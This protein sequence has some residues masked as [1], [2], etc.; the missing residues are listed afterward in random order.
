MYECGTYPARN[1]EIVLNSFYTPDDIK[2]REIADDIIKTLIVDSIED[3]VVAAYNFVI[4][5]DIYTPD[6][7]QF[8][9]D[10]WW[11]YPYETLGHVLVGGSARKMYGDC[12]DTSFL[13][14]SLLIALGIPSTNIRVGVSD[15][16]AWVECK[17][18]NTWCLFET[19][20]SRS[21][22]NFIPSSSVVG[23]SFVYNVRVYI[24]ENGCDYVR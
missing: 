11:Q 10:D 17:V 24:Y 23:S 7:I 2:V 19:T 3:R 6:K 18:G 5:N 4:S 21:F 12:E 16:H 13:L 22:N 9:K 8:G 20:S 15:V 1:H 14:A